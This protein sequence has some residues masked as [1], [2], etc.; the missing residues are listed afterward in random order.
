MAPKGRPCAAALAAGLVLAGCGRFEMPQTLRQLAP[1]AGPQEAPTNAA[2][3]A[4][5]VLFEAPIAWDG[6]YSLGGVWVAHPDAQ[7]PR[8]VR[9]VESE[10]GLAVDGALFRSAG[11]E[12]RISSDAAAA[13]GL[14]AGQAATILVT[15]REDAATTIGEE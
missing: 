1:V 3:P 7:E 13:L 9:L 10:S 11:G 8:P 12:V 15:P 5:A 6:R 4:G 2:A 14:A